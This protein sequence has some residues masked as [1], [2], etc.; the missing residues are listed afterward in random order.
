VHERVQA[1]NCMWHDVIIR[2]RD[3]KQAENSNGTP[4]TGDGKEG[5]ST[6]SKGGFALAIIPPQENPGSAPVHMQLINT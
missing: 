6:A 3:M 4:L 1:E 2:T 5:G